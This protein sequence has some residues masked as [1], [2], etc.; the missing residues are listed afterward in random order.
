MRAE[1]VSAAPVLEETV[2]LRRSGTTVV[3]NSMATTVKRAC[4]TEG[5]DEEEDRSWAC[6]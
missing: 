6:L 5:E 3:P 1:R 2:M 4:L